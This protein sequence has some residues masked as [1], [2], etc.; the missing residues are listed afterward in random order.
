MSPN[1]RDSTAQSKR[2]ALLHFLH[3]SFLSNIYLNCFFQEACVNGRM[4][5]SRILGHP[6]RTHCLI[7]TCYSR[8]CFGGVGT[9]CFFK[10]LGLERHGTKE[11]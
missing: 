8:L 1:K 5:G 7:L 3:F 9:F 4:T 6:G 11:V 10:F 2:N